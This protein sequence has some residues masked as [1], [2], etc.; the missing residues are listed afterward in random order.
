MAQFNQNLLIAAILY[1]K[2]DPVA[3]IT[4]SGALYSTLANDSFFRCSANG[5]V[6]IPYRLKSERKESI[7]LYHTP[8]LLRNGQLTL[9]QAINQLERVDLKYNCFSLFGGKK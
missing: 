3:F 9:T 1:E 5:V 8:Y 6:N 2:S 4:P 7:R